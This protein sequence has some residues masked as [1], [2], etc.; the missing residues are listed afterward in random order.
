MRLCREAIHIHILCSLSLNA[1]YIYTVVDLVA[2][3]QKQIMVFNI[4]QP[5]TGKEPGDVKHTRIHLHSNYYFVFTVRENMFFY[6]NM[7]YS[8]NALRHIFKVYLCIRSTE[9][10]INFN[11]WPLKTWLA[12]LVR[13]LCLITSLFLCHRSVRRCKVL[14]VWLYCKY[15][16]VPQR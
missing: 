3:M 14:I 2:M 13:T 12:L 9:T 10:L 7:N 8:Q 1:G 4:D 15:L 5:L 16:L 6:K 11:D